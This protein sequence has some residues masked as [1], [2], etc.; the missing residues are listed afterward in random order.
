M[1]TEEQAEVECRPYTVDER[2]ILRC[3]ACR[4][5][6]GRED[7]KEVPGPRSHYFSNPGSPDIWP[8]DAEGRPYPWHRWREPTPE[9]YRAELEQDIGHCDVCRAHPADFQ[10]FTHTVRYTVEH[11]PSR[12][13]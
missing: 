12:I 7:V 13:Y 6:F 3:G 9:E 11:V 10:I 5:P 2:G 1:I 8:F 4:D